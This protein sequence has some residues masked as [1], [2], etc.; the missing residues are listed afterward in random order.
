MSLERRL[1]ARGDFA[2][3]YVIATRLRSPRCRS[4][5]APATRCKRNGATKKGPAGSRS[6]RT[7]GRLLRW[8]LGALFR[9]A[10]SARQR[11]YRRGHRCH[12]GHRRRSA[13]AP[14]RWDGEPRELD[15]RLVRAT[16]ALVS[17]RVRDR[18]NGELRHVQSTGA[19]RLEPQGPPRFTTRV[20]F[21]ERPRVR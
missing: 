13:P 14:S 12:C 21:Q 6:T 17:P 1:G 5:S 10:K 4:C 16:R 19:L 7:P 3:A 15:A 8:R 11:R 20:A 2:Q 9:R 18:Q